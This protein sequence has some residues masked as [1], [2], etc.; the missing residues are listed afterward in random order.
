[1][2]SQANSTNQNNENNLESQPQNTQEFQMPNVIE[3]MNIEGFFEV[4]DTIPTH[5]PRNLWDQIKIYKNG[6]TKSFYVYDY[7]NN[8]WQSYTTG[9]NFAMGGEVISM[10]SGGTDERT[11]T[12]GFQPKLIV[13]FAFMSSEHSGFSIGAG[14]A[15]DNFQCLYKEGYTSWFAGGRDTE[16]IIYCQ[17]YY[18][19]TPTLKAIL[20]ELNSTGFKLNYSAD[21][22]V[23]NTNVLWVA[24]G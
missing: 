19:G 11:Y 12:A 9:G 16:N 20:S 21:V 10:G 8:E 23:L 17:R 15:I 22:N 7:K 14:T 4:V 3:L 13:V 6:I 18:S 24:M 1:M 5:T 2:S